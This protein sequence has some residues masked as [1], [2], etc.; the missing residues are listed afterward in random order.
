RAQDFSCV[1]C[2]HSCSSKGFLSNKDGLRRHCS[3]MHLHQPR[4]LKS[5][6]LAKFGTHGLHGAGCS[7]RSILVAA[8]PRLR[9]R[10]RV[11]RISGGDLTMRAMILDAA[12]SLLRLAEMPV[13][14]P[15][16]EQVLIRVHACGVCRT[17]L[18][19]ADGELPH[20]KLPLIL[21]HEIVGTVE[22]VG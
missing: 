12:H 14:S 7:G 6:E 3:V 10:I 13:P 1:D 11:N 22:K 18:H 21:G 9:Y 16:P 2:V 17:D 19:V 20:P 15:G 5:L 8:V 4:R